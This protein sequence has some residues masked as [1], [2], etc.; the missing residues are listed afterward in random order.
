MKKGS[1]M[2]VKLLVPLN[3]F[4]AM[5]SPVMELQVSNAKMEEK[6]MASAMGT[7]QNI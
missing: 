6:E 1:A 2:R 5:N 4:K 7:E 3:T